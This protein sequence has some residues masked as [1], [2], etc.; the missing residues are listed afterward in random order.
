MKIDYISDIH[1]DFHVKVNSN[2]D[3]YKLHTT[4]FLESLLPEKLGE[5]MIIA[6]DLSHYNRQS[7]WIL[8]Y[9][10]DKYKQVFYTWGNHDFYLISNKQ[11]KKYW[12]SYHKVL[13]LIQLTEHL[14]N[15]QVLQDYNVYDYEGI[16]FSGSTNWYSLDSFEELNFFNTYMNDSRLIKHFDIKQANYLEGIKY[17]A[18]KNVD[19]IVTHVPPVVIESHHKYGNTYCYL[20]QLKE[21]KATHWVFGHCH[22]QNVYEKA[23]TKFYINALG[24]PSESSGVQIQSFE[25]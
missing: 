14:Q 3:K 2:E 23:G 18:L 1:L 5:V 16:S 8:E 24:Y 25:V 15:V 11:N 6:G 19:V 22:E 13:E 7:I 4:E 9:F 10:A 17:D 20:N 12:K 21:L